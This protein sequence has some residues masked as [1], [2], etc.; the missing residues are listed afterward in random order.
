[1]TSLE[2]LSLSGT[3]VTSAGVK[4]LQT[5]LPKCKIFK[6]NFKLNLN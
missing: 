3:K 1:L 6:S 2:S 5:A 4:H